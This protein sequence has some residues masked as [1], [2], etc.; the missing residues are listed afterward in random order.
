MT[1]QFKGSLRSEEANKLCQVCTMVL[2]NHYLDITR[3]CGSLSKT[4]WL[5]FIRNNRLRLFDPFQYT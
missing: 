2:K 1:Y 3:Y 5:T 4:P